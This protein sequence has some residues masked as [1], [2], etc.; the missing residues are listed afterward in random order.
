MAQ[1]ASRVLS[2]SQ[3]ALLAE[4]GEERTAEVGTVLFKIGDETYPFIALLEGEAQVLDESGHEIVRHG[5]SG[6]LG[7][8]NLLT[9]PTVFLTVRVTKPMRYLADDRQRLRELLFQDTAL[10]DLLLSS[11]VQRR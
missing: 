4:H 9:G 3:L 5:P 6:F 10:S 7:E 2:S 8:L 11:L 1:P